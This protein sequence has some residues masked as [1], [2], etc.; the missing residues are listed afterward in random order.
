MSNITDKM[1][2]ILISRLE[3]IPKDEVDEHVEKALREAGRK[4][5][6]TYGTYRQAQT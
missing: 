2:T 4:G 6:I 5:V 3:M 1:M